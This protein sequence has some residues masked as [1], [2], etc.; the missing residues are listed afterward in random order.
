MLGKKARKA[1]L[2]ATRVSVRKEMAGPRVS[3]S[4][5]IAML[6]LDVARNPEQPSATLDGTGEKIIPATRPSKPEKA[7]IGV[8]GGERRHQKLRIENSLVDE[9]G[10][11]VK[12]KKGGHVEVTVTAESKT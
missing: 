5:R 4:A 3:R 7:Q 11:N 2:A 12:L 1:L 6:K 10:D 8:H 9:H